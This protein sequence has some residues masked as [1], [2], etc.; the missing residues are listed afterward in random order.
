MV[1]STDVPHTA[2]AA[3]VA[4]V[5]SLYRSMKWGAGMRDKKKPDELRQLGVIKAR[6]A[7]LG[8]DPTDVLQRRHAVRWYL[9]VCI[10]DSV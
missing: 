10:E 8:F 7:E 1:T 5:S 4:I 6:V 2:D 9:S 3:S